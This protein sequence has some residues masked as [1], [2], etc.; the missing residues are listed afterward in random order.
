MPN[1]KVDCSQWIE[2]GDF[3]SYIRLL[4][5]ETW[6]EKNKLQ[7]CWSEICNVIYGIGNPD[8]S[9]IGVTVGYVLGISPG[10]SLSLAV[11]VLKQKGMPSRWYHTAKS[12]LTAF[13]DSPGTT[14]QHLLGR[15]RE[16]Q[17]QA[18]FT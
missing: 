18:A 3:I 17:Y 14:G 8:I 7:I 1:L 13:V 9:G 16:P 10:I 6:F 2:L 11:I 4:D 15:Y 12:G 5:Y